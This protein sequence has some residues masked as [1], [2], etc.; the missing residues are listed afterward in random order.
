MIF[1]HHCRGQSFVELAFIIPILLL[2]LL[3]MFEI[4]LAFNAFMQV[5][6]AARNAARFAAT[7]NPYPQDNLGVSPSAYDGLNECFTIGSVTGTQNYFRTAA[8]EAALNLQP[9]DMFGVSD[10]TYIVVSIFTINDGVVEYRFDSNQEN[11]TMGWLN[12]DA[13]CTGNNPVACGR[14]FFCNTSGPNDTWT[15]IGQNA[16]NVYHSAFSIADI[17]SRLVDSIDLTGQGITSITTAPD[18]AFVLVE[19]FHV[20]DLVL[21]IPIISNIIGSQ[22][23]IHNFEVMPLAFANCAEPGTSIRDC[24][25]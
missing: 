3:G 9:I 13:D 24:T 15:C 11:G 2:I 18:M 23:P 22:I 7:N 12:L 25:N 19:V 20:H 6:D 8:C 1:R 10:D 5:N 17:N 21:N 14:V 4:T 16:D